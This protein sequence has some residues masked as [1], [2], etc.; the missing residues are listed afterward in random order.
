MLLELQYWMHHDLN[1]VVAKCAFPVPVKIVL[2]RPELFFILGENAAVRERENVDGQ[3]FS[4]P[5][6]GLDTITS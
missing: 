4:Q 2:L 6:P 1:P 5:D 3:F